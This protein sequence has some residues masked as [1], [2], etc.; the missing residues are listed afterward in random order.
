MQV[1]SQAK[2]IASTKKNPDKPIGILRKLMK[3]EF[4]VGFD[5]AQPPE[6]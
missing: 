5:F 2:N 4:Q 1:I 3:Y 6:T